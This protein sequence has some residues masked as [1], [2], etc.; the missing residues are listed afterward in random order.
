MGD[1]AGV[2]PEIAVKALGPGNSLPCRVVV[3]GDMCA[4]DRANR[5][6]GSQA[7]LHEI[8]H[9]REAIDGS[10][11][12][13]ETHQ[14][15][16]S[17]YSPGASSATCGKASYAYIIESI[18]LATS[19]AVDGIVTNPISKSALNNA[20]IDY[21]GHTEILAHETGARHFSMVFMLDN[22]YVVHVTTHCSLREAIT[23]ISEQRVLT[24][25]RLLHAALHELV[26]A[27]PRIAVAGLNPHAGEGGLFGDEEIRHIVPAIDR[28][29]D[30]GIRITGPLPPD[31]VF[32][33]AFRGEFDGIVSML[34]DHG[35]TALKS[36]DFERGVNITLGLPI[37]R[38][39]VG[40]G[41]A[42]DIAGTGKASHRSLIEA[43]NVAHLLCLARRRGSLLPAGDQ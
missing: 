41:T 39:S 6:L 34:H 19:G 23:S 26:G 27:D 15:T 30:A 5:I 9:P 29:R 36:R 22:V 10:I 37:V 28:A 3:A 21:P 7:R 1:P 38:T 18:R 43:I 40:H 17:D 13:V 24:H 35:F 20:G 25:I 11:N 31:T 33:R 4:L 8:S 2:G 16:C 42:F 32:M 14:I 12:V